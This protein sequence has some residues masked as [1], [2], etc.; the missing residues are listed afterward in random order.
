MP[1]RVR[2]DLKVS[3]AWTSFVLRALEQIGFESV[4]LCKA[5][6][7]EPELLL[8]PEARIPRDVSGMIWREVTDLSN[9]PYLA[10]HAAK[11]L[12]AGPNNLLAHLGMSCRNLH[13][14]LTF[15]AQY[16][17]LVAH[18][19]VLTLGESDEHLHL[20]LNR[21]GGYLEITRHEIEFMA[22]LVLKF[23][24]VPL[25]E[26]LVPDEVRFKH[27]APEAD[28]GEYERVL[29]GPVRFSCEQDEVVVS[30]RI[31]FRKSPNY[32][33]HVVAQLERLVADRVRELQSTEIRPEV[34]ARVTLALPKGSPDLDEIA[35]VLHMSK[36]TLQRR[37]ADEGVSFRDVVEDARRSTA[38]E[39]LSDGLSVV[40]TARKIGFS[41]VR[42]FKRAF[43]RWTGMTPTEFAGNA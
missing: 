8:D 16:Q 15:G 22:A 33:A 20:R 7:I 21:I 6:G 43:R 3:G 29:G 38:L 30:K 24:S 4:E 12:D 39:A 37:L 31:A 9:D 19:E 13:Q 42:P 27:P 34:T 26:T 11:A 25:G 32:N 23:C 2:E 40:E 5:V 35:A 10:L 1:H 18:G 14:A 41:D 28:I 36:R 17:R